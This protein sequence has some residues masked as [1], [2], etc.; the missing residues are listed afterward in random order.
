MSLVYVDTSVLVKRYVRT[1]ASDAVDDLFG[2]TERRFALSELC[3]I[4]VESVLARLARQR[5]GA[6]SRLSQQRLRFE[7]DLRLG[8]FELQSLAQPVLLRARQLIA[9]GKAPLATLDALHLAT[10][11]TIDADAIATDDKQLARASKAHRLDIIS[12]V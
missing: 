12:F 2:D 3:L 1:P 6:P 8:F 5:R 11:L 7:S 9:D 4:E 10:A